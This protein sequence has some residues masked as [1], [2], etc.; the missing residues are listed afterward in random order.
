MYNM[1]KQMGRK[2]FL[3]VSKVTTVQLTPE[4][5]AILDAYRAITGESQASAIRK[6]V[7]LLRADG[8]EIESRRLSGYLREAILERDDRTC[9]YCDR[10][11]SETVQLVVDH[12]IPIKLGG[13]NDASNLAA[14]CVDCNITKKARLLSPEKYAQVYEIISG[15]EMGDIIKRKPGPVAKV[16]GPVRRV[17]LFDE[18]SDVRLDVLAGCRRLSRSEVVRDLVTV[19]F[20]REVGAAPHPVVSPDASCLRRPVAL[21]IDHAML[22]DRHFSADALNDVL[23]LLPNAENVRQGCGDQ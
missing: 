12:I 14:S 7:A 8:E 4:D 10:A 16:V 21:G 18:L 1:G 19:A 2:P 9:I 23:D 5:E 20:G 13:T 22:G 11:E 17:I 6:G 3:D 15:R